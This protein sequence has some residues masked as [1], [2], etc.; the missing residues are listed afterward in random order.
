MVVPAKHAEVIVIIPV[1]GATCTQLVDVNGTL[2]VSSKPV[3]VNTGSTRVQ[4]ALIAVNALIAC[5]VRI[6]GT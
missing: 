3:Y 5:T 2:F 4:A 1:V 6:P